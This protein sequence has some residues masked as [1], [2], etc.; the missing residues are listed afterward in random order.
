[1]AGTLPAGYDSS[2]FVDEAPDHMVNA[3]AIAI[4][5]AAQGHVRST[6]AH[7]QACRADE[8]SS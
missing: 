2:E 7:E 3:L 8:R 1:M 5:Q 6:R 4:P